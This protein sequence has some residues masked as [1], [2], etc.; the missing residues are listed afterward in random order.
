MLVDYVLIRVAMTAVVPA[1]FNVRARP[2]ESSRL[3]D[4]Y[5]FA[6]KA[7]EGQRK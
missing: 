6:Q 5:A 4:R 2:R 3:A 7:L 1:P